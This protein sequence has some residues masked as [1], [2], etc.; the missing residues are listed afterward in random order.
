MPREISNVGTSVRARLQNLSRKTGQ[1][2]ELILT[3]YA[4]ERLLYRL[5]TRTTPPVFV[6]Q[7]LN[8]N[9]SMNF[10]IASSSG[11]TFRL[12]S[13]LGFRSLP[14]RRNRQIIMLEQPPSFSLSCLAGP[15]WC[16]PA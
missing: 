7:I 4:L 15:R 14:S 5:S 3:R 6:E 8:K 13:F 10:A 2:F 9:L 12:P 16:L 11:V 1:S